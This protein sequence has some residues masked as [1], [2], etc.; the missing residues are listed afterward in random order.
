MANGKA[1][2]RAAYP[3]H[4]AKTAKQRIE[5]ESP[6]YVP[7][8]EKAFSGEFFDG[9]IEIDNSAM[10][11][12]RNLL[13]RANLVEKLDTGAEFN[14]KEREQ[15]GGMVKDRSWFGLF[16]ELQ[17]GDSLAYF[18]TPGGAF[19]VKN[20]NTLFG[21]QL[22]DAIIDGRKKILNELMAE[23]GFEQL[24][25]DYRS[26]AFKLPPKESADFTKELNDISSV[27]N[28]RMV[29][30]ISKAIDRRIVEG[31]SENKFDRMRALLHSTDVGFRMNFGI[32]EVGKPED[33]SDKSN[34]V[35]AL[36][37]CAQMAQL[38]RHLSDEMYGESYDRDSVIQEISGS[39]ET[40][41]VNELGNRLAEKNVVDETGIEYKIFTV[42]NGR[43]V[44]N[45]DLLRLARKGDFKPKAGHE[46]VFA[47]VSQ[48]V[49]RINI[50]DVVKP[51]TAIEASSGTIAKR[52]EKM[53][54]FVEKN[55]A[56]KYVLRADLS[57][58]DKK[59]LAY[60]LKKDQKDSTYDA[61]EFFHKEAMQLKDCE[62]VNVD[63]LDLGVDLLLEYEQLIQDIGEDPSKLEEASL[64]AGDKITENMRSVRAK[65]LAVFEK[66]FPGVK[67]IDRVGGD[68]I[69]IA[70]EDPQDAQKMEEFLLALQHET[71]TRV[72]KT[73]VG[74]SERHSEAEWTG[75]RAAG[76][77]DEYLREHLSAMKRA[78]RGSEMCKQVEKKMRIAE[79]ALQ[80]MKKISATDEKMMAAELSRMEIGQYKN[81]AVKEDAE[82][83]FK[84]LCRRESGNEIDELSFEDVIEWIGQKIA[85]ITKTNGE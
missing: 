34:V 53:A 15:L 12:A 62:Y 46:D 45:R 6:V 33:D 36:A 3:L 11:R 2:D 48:Y 51:F 39:R 64:K 37:E 84:V 58:L 13:T 52:V 29:E 61:P 38:S 32:S 40:E 28:E 19:S 35:L 56:G 43:R 24:T 77:D 81:I 26:A 9:N 70:I 23:S 73:V 69:A 85:S 16:N 82:G 42:E 5:K 41:G 59:R 76:A 75:E 50:L 30:V 55:S 78:E 47:Q 74:G 7:G 31:I 71:G 8:G 18:S 22:T 17:A 63:V 54:K 80:Q 20:L 79:L 27:L 4:E 25:Q 10:E 68:E 66:F 44:M 1:R 65:A 83:N 67:P 21:E 57:E 60:E 14:E 72:I 49:R